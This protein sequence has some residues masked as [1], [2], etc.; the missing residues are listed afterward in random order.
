MSKAAII[1][2]VML[3]EKA[4][5]IEIIFKRQ[6]IKPGASKACAKGS[7]WLNKLFY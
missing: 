7:H 2:L 4:E 5:L 3:M 1:V 6:K